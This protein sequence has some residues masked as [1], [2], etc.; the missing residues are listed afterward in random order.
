MS[1]RIRHRLVV[2]R[3]LHGESVIGIG[4]I[5]QTGG[6]HLATDKRLHPQVLG[7]PIGALILHL[8]DRLF[9]LHGHVFGIVVR[10]A[11]LMLLVD[12]RHENCLKHV[13]GHKMPG[14][15]AHTQQLFHAVLEVWPPAAWR[16]MVVLLV[17]L[18][19]HAGV[20]KLGT[21]KFCDLEK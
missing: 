2:V 1:Q 17:Q 8:V 20:M 21:K 10:L 6:I 5:P 3:P 15:D 16:L 4:S 7:Q 19:A 14:P 12:Y 11:N 18:A 13:Y 9:P